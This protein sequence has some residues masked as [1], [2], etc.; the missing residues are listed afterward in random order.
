MATEERLPPACAFAISVLAEHNQDPYMVPEEAVEAAQQHM[1]TCARC[2]ASQRPQRPVGNSTLRKKKRLRPMADNGDGAQSA[3]QTLLEE[4]PSATATHEQIGNGSEYPLQQSTQRSLITSTPTET[5]DVTPQEISVTAQQV[6]DVLDCQ[7][8]RPFLQDYANALTEGQPVAVLYPEIHEHIEHCDMGCQM[9]LEL[10]TQEAKKNSKYKRNLVRDPF[11]A[12]GWELSGFFR[13]G[14]VPM[15]AKALAYGTLMLLLVVASLGA[16]VGFNWD[17]SHYH[18]A[19]ANAMPIPDGVGLS[20]GLKIFDAC[21]TSAFQ[22]KR[23]AAQD[24]LQT[25]SSKADGLLTSALHIAQNDT[26]GCNG[27]EAAVYLEDL[28]VRQ[29][30][31]PFSM[32]VVSFDS[33]PGNTNPIN[34]SDRHFLY[35]ANTQELVGVAIAQKQYNTA[36]LKVPGAPLLYLV[37]ANTTGLESG[38]GQV[39]TMIASLAQSTDYQPLGLLVNH[40]HPLLAVLGLGPDNQLQG[41]LP[42]MCRTGVPVIAPTTLDPAIFDQIVEASLYNHCA[43]GFSFAR[44]AADDRQQSVLAANYAYAKLKAKY[45]A[46]IYNP[47][48]LS[49]SIAVQ[50]FIDNFS[51]NPDTHIVARETT[52]T[53]DAASES[54]D[55]SQRIHENLSTAL[56]DAL[57]AKPRPDVIFASVQTND[58]Y[59]LAQAI[60]RLPQNQQPTLIVSGESIQL[61]TLQALSQWARQNQFAQPHIYVS[62]ATATQSKLTEEWQ[63]QFYASFCTSFAPTGSSCSSVGAL[64]QGALLFADGLESVTNSIGPVTDITHLPTREQLVKKIKDVHFTGVSNTIAFHSTVNS[65]LTNQKAAPVL[66]NIQDDGSIQI[67]K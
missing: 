61:K 15:S 43:T 55:Q 12:I 54:A 9:L 56:N 1:V 19:Y 14:Q 6:D 24:M 34:G 50:G 49:A 62:V 30:G 53:S 44:L 66:L 67:V 5:V 47:N 45:G 25:P 29:S 11:S 37:L 42:T 10:F 38:A 40:T 21:N 63:K 20:D 3:M 17:E 39:A 52:I 35:A 60:A 41:S 16:L 36:Q 18:A 27:G 22:D 59:T 4:R 48:N 65:L 46:V 8:C 33:T 64:D 28:H 23:S 32:V 26:S 31:H 2:V 7:Q 58:A 57:Q 13:A 51:K